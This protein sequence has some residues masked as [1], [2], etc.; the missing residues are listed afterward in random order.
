MFYGQ[1]NRTGPTPMHLHQD[2]LVHWR[3]HHTAPRTANKLSEA[4]RGTVEAIGYD[5]KA[6]NI[7]PDEVWV[8]WEFVDYDG[9]PV[10]EGYHR[11]LAEIEQIARRED[12]DAE[13]EELTRFESAAF[14]D[15]YIRAIED[16]ADGLGYDSMQMHAG[17]GHDPMNVAEVYDTGIGFGVSE[18]GFSHIKEEYASWDGCYTAVSTLIN[19]SYELAT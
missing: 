19:A 4:T 5:S 3:P 18:D 15:R 16:A 12:V 2:A 17:A 8:V 11:T 13:S 7:V 9:D 14:D 6:I 10:E 1:S